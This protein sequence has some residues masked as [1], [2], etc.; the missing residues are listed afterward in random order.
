MLTKDLHPKPVYFFLLPQDSKLLDLQGLAANSVEAAASSFTG[1]P[2]P[3]V[4]M[5]NIFHS[6]EPVDKL[7]LLVII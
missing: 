7:S 3:A 6:I 4:N 1:L 5:V 2:S